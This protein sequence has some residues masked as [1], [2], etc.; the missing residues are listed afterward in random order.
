M[1]RTSVPAY[2]S[3]AANVL[4]GWTSA[5]T[6]LVASAILASGLVGTLLLVRRFPSMAGSLLATL[7]VI[8]IWP[9]IQDR[10]L[11]PV[12][13]VLGVAA[14]FAAQRVLDRVPVR[15]RRAAVLGVSLLTAALLVKNGRLRIE[16]VRGSPH[17]PG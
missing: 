9:Y 8:A 1:I 14:A 6:L 13:P 5:K 10:F 15:G 11:T 12:L 2:W 4:V 3:S 7:G 17:S 16:S